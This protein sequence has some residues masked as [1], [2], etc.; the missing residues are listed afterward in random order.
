MF[1]FVVIASFNIPP[2]DNLGL[3]GPAGPNDRMRASKIAW[4]HVGLL[5]QADER[6]RRL[7]E[8]RIKPRNNVDRLGNYGEPTPFETSTRGGVVEKGA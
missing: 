2:S 6:S 3:H 5:V 7:S 8:Y 1:Q 4:S